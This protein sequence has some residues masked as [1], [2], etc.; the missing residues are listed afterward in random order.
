[1]PTAGVSG[2]AVALTTAGGVL[3]V[4]AIRNQTPTDVIKGVIKKPTSGR[5]LGSPFTSAVSGVARIALDNAAAV[6]IGAAAGQAVSALGSGALVAEARQHLGAKYVFATA[7]PTTFDCS[8]LVVYC[9]RKTLL[10][11]CP[12][13]TTYT[14]SGVLA[15]AGWKRVTPAQ[16]A[17]GDVI[18]RS[19]HMGIA[20]SATTYINAPHTGTVVKE[21]RIPTK[22]VGW[23]GYR[24]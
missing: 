23:W 17:A 14:A 19:G 4:A 8:G 13:F 3:L 21:V 16:F 1:V 9:L 10:P 11:S 18:I 6:G 12:R 24:P 5:Q 22:G 15:R 2:L 7:G 20:S